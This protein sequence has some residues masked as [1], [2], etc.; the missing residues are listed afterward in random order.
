MTGTYDAAE[1]A[2][3][4]G[5]GV[6]LTNAVASDTDLTIGRQ[7]DNDGIDGVTTLDLS[8]TI[9][10]ADGSTYAVAHL[11]DLAF[12]YCEGI[13]SVTLPAGLTS[14]SAVAGP[15]LTMALISFVGAAAL[16]RDHR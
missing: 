1:R 5:D 7:T 10:G 11:D 13:T 12:Y 3:T 9:T 4:N 2:L 16:H 15:L 8:G 6:V 14:I